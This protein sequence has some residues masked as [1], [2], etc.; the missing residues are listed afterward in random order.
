M[1]VT[2]A[3]ID[4]D[5]LRLRHEFLCMP[6]LCLSVPQVALLTGVR[7]D[8]AT[9]ILATLEAEGFLEQLVDGTFRRANALVS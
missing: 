9:D 6:G 8:H 3:P 4:A 5:L 1:I 2:A 7:L